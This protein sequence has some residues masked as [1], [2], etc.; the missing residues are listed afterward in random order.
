MAVCLFAHYCFYFLKIMFFNIT[1]HFLRW[2]WGRWTSISTS[3]ATFPP[4]ELLIS[5]RLNAGAVQTA[6]LAVFQCI[7]V[8]NL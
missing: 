7:F 2:P 6:L 8:D 1:V 5:E 3:I 4:P